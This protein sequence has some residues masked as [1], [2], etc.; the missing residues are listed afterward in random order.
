M[1][2]GRWTSLA[3]MGIVA[4]TLSLSA[5]PLPTTNQPA[6][7]FEAPVPLAAAVNSKSS[8]VS[9]R[10]REHAPLVHVQR[11]KAGEIAC[12]GPA[13]ADG[14]L[15]SMYAPGYNPRKQP[16]DTPGPAGRADFVI[17]NPLW[18]WPQPGGLGTTV[19]L[20]YSYS[21][22]LDG[23]MR[24]VLP[25]ELQAATQE[26]TSRWAA[27]SP[28]VFLEVPDSGPTTIADVSYPPGTTPNLRFGHHPID[29]Q[30]G[31]LAH[32]F[33]PFD[34]TGDGLSGD[35]HFDT[36]EQWGVIPTASDIDYLEVALHELGHALGLGHQNPPP[37]A[38]MN[39]FYASRF[40]G[41][42]TSFLFQDDIDGIQ[43]L[44]GG[45]TPPPPPPPPAPDQIVVVNYN[46]G[47]R[48]LSLTGDN[49][50][51]GLS[52]SMRGNTLMVQAGGS[53]QLRL[54]NSTLNRKSLSFKGVNK[55]SK[56]NITG[57][58]AGGDDSVACTSLNVNNLSLNLG[59][60]ADRAVLSLCNVT[61]LQLNGGSDSD[62][63]TL[64][65]TSSVI[66]T[67]VS[68]AFP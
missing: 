48:T 6:S 53:T 19:L 60:G 63:D 52:V 11:I 46:S 17:Q 43:A 58:M 38:I 34:V 9:K 5:T 44:Y 49:S 35:M 37:T 15:C 16:S 10:T 47:S 55:N 42:G 51:G 36:T 30:F 8:A 4:A 3:L 22:L 20:T 61:T 50:S 12:C 14:I 24:G 65:F 25:A 23:G 32:G 7:D 64:I 26:V 54:G 68:T 39:P 45:P 2:F 40:S 67:N 57:N 28:L 18:K 27:V 13:Q 21:N 33:F 31:V 59:A 62:I 66:Q 41:L 1:H 56:I 29:G